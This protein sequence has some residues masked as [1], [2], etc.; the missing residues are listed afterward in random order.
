MTTL[1]QVKLQALKDRASL[2]AWNAIFRPMS[3]AQRIR[4]FYRIFSPDEVLMTSSFGTSSAFLLHWVQQAAPEQKVHFIDT[5]FHFSESLAYKNTLIQHF[6]L[7]VEVLRGDA[8]LHA[9][10]RKNKTWQSNPT[11]CCRVNKL[12]P[13]EQVK[14][15]YRVWISGLMSWQ[16][17]HRAEMKIFERKGSLLKFHPLLDVDEG[18]Y[19]YFQSYYK[20][21]QHPLLPYGYDSI[22][23]MHCT[24][25]GQGREGRWQGHNKN[26][27]GLHTG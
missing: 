16:T 25:R 3:F 9:Q 24:V 26:E 8:A 12:Q 27:C 18:E 6:D 21:P 19:L 10:T 22:G 7:D 13:L 2:E 15:Q 17:P 1:I 4:N 5:G 20:W 11:A 14:D 23:C